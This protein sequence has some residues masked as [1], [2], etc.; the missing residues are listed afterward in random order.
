MKLTVTHVDIRPY[1]EAEQLPTEVR[2]RPRTGVWRVVTA[3]L[4]SSVEQG[5]LT[6]ATGEFIRIPLIPYQTSLDP[7][8]SLAFAVQLGALVLA[9]CGRPTCLHLAVGHP[10]QDLRSQGVEGLRLWLGMALEG[11]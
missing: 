3:P 10:L 5:W 2:S 8:V 7:A 6:E 11:S 9:R 4:L 1:L